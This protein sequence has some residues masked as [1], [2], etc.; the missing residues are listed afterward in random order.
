MDTSKGSGLKEA[1]IKLIKESVEKYNDRRFISIYRNV[2]FK[3]AHELISNVKENKN[4]VISIIVPM[5]GEMDISRLETFL[6]STKQQKDVHM[7]VILAEQTFD[8]ERYIDI[9]K[10]YGVTYVC[11]HVDEN[12]NG[13]HF[14]P[15]RIRNV[16]I[17][18]S[19]GHFIYAADSDVVY[20]D[21]YYMS[22]VVSILKD[23]PDTFLVWPK[24][25]H[26]LIENQTT[27][28]KDFLNNPEWDSMAK[29]FI[30]HGKW[31]VEYITDNITKHEAIPFREMMIGDRRMIIREKD[32]ID[33]SNNLDKFRGWDPVWLM[34]CRHD[35]AI[36]ARRTHID[37]VGGYSEAF[38]RWG[39]EDFDLQW[40]LSELFCQISLENIS[41]F[42]TIHLDHNKG[43]FDK[44]L[45]ERNSG[46]HWQRR[47]KGIAVAIIFDVM[48]NRSNYAKRLR[49][50]WHIN[51]G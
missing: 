44:L 19:T 17:E 38:Y 5:Y 41:D 45:F 25:K 31:A 29:N 42:E 32:Y 8:V 15:G 33:Y 43:W 18:K 37:I 39:Y 14:N 11:D 16:G 3:I 35:G 48:E 9:A 21:L 1:T 2:G 36:A 30:K 10:K 49:T 23:Y 50:H 24:M 13:K 27:L 46:I 20:P 47:E 6:V 28:H 26:L 40:K 4:E 34:S 7:E 22:K 12:V 51:L